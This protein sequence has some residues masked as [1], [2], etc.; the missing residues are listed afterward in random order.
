MRTPKPHSALF[1]FAFF[2]F[3]LFILFGVH[4]GLFAQ[5]EPAS[6]EAAET[7]IPVPE[8]KSREQNLLIDIPLT[9][10]EV[11]AINM[12]GN[13][14]W[15]LWG[16]DSHAAYF[17][18][19]S[20]RANLQAGAWSWEK[21]LGGDTFL[22]N[23][24]FHPYA[25]GLYFASAR[26][27]NLNYYLSIISPIIGSIQWETFAETEMPA[28]NDFITSAFGGIVLGEMVH[29]LYIE[30]DKGGIAGKIAS[31]ILNPTS[32]I[33]AALRGYGPE[34][35]PSKIYDT[36]LAFG[37][38]WLNARFYEANDDTIFWNTTSVFF[39]FNLIYGNPYT[40]HSKTPFDQFDLNISLALAIPQLYNLSFIS[41]GYLASWLLADDEVNH[42][43]SG[44]TIHFDAFVTD[45][46]FMDLNNG[47]E[48]LSFNANSLDY[49]VKWRRILNESFDLSLKTHLGFSP[50]AVAGY[51]GGEDNDDY[52]MFL[53][54]ANVKFFF[55]LQQ[56]R[57][58]GGRKKG[59]ALALNFC[60]YDT[61]HLPKTPNFD[62]NTHFLSSKMSYS[63]PLT[64]KFSF[65]VADS[66][67]LL[68]CRLARGEELPNILRWYNNTQIGI[69]VSFS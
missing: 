45:R 28:T 44:V 20:I 21:G 4:G 32:R 19:D 65:Y 14:Y 23:Q 26:S 69:K 24:L 40:A 5:Q 68:H 49:T 53:F 36:S 31:T 42:A 38:S 48:N 9:L 18:L 67:L 64:G 46:G 62:V 55:E 56:T 39:D 7:I 16:P 3:I 25:G 15:R 27:N 22:V 34:E 54:G 29:R 30:L 52:N 37:T 11:T 41:D 12:A 47:R 8:Y 17:T 58:V 43:S 51:N 61:W 6:P 57:E 50:W 59:R 2:F 66:F 10:A 60:F 33:T 1:I 13:L 63:L 35:G